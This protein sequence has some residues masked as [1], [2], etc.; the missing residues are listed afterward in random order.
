MAD[1]ENDAST[2]ATGAKQAEMRLKHAQAEYKK[3]KP[4][5][6][7]AEK[8]HANINAERA[9]CAKEVSELEEKLAKLGFDEVEAAK[10]CK[11]RDMG[12]PPWHYYKRSHINLR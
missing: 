2:A 10:V 4:L 7:N 1:A 11:S 8:A 6:A 5:A 9:A 3:K 12:E